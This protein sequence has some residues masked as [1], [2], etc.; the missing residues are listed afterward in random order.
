MTRNRLCS[1]RRRELLL[2]S[3]GGLDWVID[4]FSLVV[5]HPIAALWMAN[6]NTIHEKAV[7][8]MLGSASY[9]L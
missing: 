3:A 5:T 7:L 4:T 9:L 8:L 6:S 1:S 2:P